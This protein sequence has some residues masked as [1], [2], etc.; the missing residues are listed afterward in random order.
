MND[1]PSQNPSTMNAFYGNPN[2]GGNA[3]KNWEKT[4][5]VSIVPPYPMVL[6]W[7]FPVVEFGEGRKWNRRYTDFYGA[8]GENAWK[9]ARDGLTHA[10]EWSAAIDAW[11]APY[12][13]DE[14]KPLWYRGMLFN[15]LYVLADGGSLW[16][17]PVG[18][19]K[20]T[21]STYSFMECF[22]YP[23]FETLDVRFYG[24]MPLVKFWPDI[25]KQVMRDF[26][27]T[28]A[29]ISLLDLVVSVDTSVVHLA[30]ALGKPVWV[31]LPFNPDF[32]WLI[33]REDSPWY[34]TARL[35]RQPRPGDWESVLDRVRSELGRNR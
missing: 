2:D 13:H 32:R 18:A 6:A 27:D 4:N 34:P 10:N 1:W 24:S 35:F 30:G 15:E 29:V 17:R 16:G 33:G 8:S 14:S 22:D 31:L 5:L 19:D 20:S 25:D 11:Q 26:A 12:T 21:H 23:Y 9:I 7:D 3:S 28:A